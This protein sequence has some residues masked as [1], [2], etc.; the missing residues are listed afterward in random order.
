MLIKELGN[1]V[2]LLFENDSGVILK[3]SNTSEIT[4]EIEINDTIEAP[5]EKDQV[6]GKMNFYL[7]NKLISSVNLIAEDSI[8]KITILNLFQKTITSWI[9]LL[10]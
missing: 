4:Q 6:L 2:N 7:D 5:I 10:R 3:K 9:T 1:T 8:S